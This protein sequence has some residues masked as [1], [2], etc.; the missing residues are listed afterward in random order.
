M[1][2]YQIREKQSAVSIDLTDV[3]GHHDELLNAFEDYATGQC[4]CPTDQFEKL[5]SMDVQRNAEQIVVRLESREGARFD[6]SAIAACL[7][8]TVNRIEGR[9]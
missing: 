6:P 4:S 7:D 8:H 3:G 1:T 5:A 9:T 2:R